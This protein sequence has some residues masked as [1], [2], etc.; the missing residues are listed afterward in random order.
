MIKKLMAVLLCMVLS[1]LLAA[2]TPFA[3]QNVNDLLRAPVLGQGQDEIQRALKAYLD[4][5]EPQY[6]FPKEGEWR[7]PLIKGDLNGDG[8]DEAVLLYSIAETS[9]LAKEMG[10]N[11]YVAVLEQVGAEWVVVQNEQGL[12]TDVASVALADLLGDGSNELLIGFS[13]PSLNAKTLALYTYQAQTLAMVHKFDYSRY[14]IGNFTG[15]NSTDLVVVSRDNEVG[16]LS[17]QHVPTMD[18]EFVELPMP[19]KLYLNFVNCVG[20]KAS[21]GY[22][23]ERLLVVDGAISIETGALASQF[24]YYSGERFYTLDDAASLTGATAR[25]NPLLK[26]RD[27]DGDGAVEIP[28]RIGRNEIQT[29]SA[30]KRLE[31]IEWMDFTGEGEEPV[32][33]EYGLLDSDRGVYVQLPEAWRGAVMVV[34]GTERGEWQLQN[35][36][37]MATLLTMRTIEPGNQP[38]MGSQRAP[39]TTSSYLVYANGLTADEKDLIRMVS[40]L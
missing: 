30:D 29:P 7:S 37:T 40:M 23:A 36:A 6:R 10:A 15:E 18:G 19:V 24:V 5:E 16:G 38:P 4:N 20:I 25:L 3:S 39:G 8:R 35:R 17:L 26:S 2:C 12:S 28:L 31:Y 13:T 14:E 33:K 34:D 1:L 9:P 32:M 11:V 27:I 22:N 21:T